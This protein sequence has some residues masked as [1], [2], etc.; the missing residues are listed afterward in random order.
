[1][2]M[3]NLFSFLSFI[4]ICVSLHH[5][6]CLCMHSSLCYSIKMNVA[7]KYILYSFSVFLV[8][9]CETKMYWRK[10]FHKKKVKW[11]ITWKTLHAR[12]KAHFQRVSGRNVWREE[13]RWVRCGSIFGLKIKFVILSRWN[14]FLSFPL[15]LQIWAQTILHTVYTHT[16][17]LMVKHK[18]S[19]YIELECRTKL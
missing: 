13:T 5:C 7:G 9:F 17:P 15:F 8:R 4:N 19:C 1:M 14:F 6:M 2:I 10:S 3:F 18:L 16:I 12:N 11:D